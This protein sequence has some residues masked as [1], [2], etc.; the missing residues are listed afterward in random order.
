MLK[1]ESHGQV[2]T[3]PEVVRQMLALRQN[4]GRCLEPSCGDGAFAR[5]LPGCVAVELDATVAPEGALIQDFLTYGLENQFETII[6]NPPYVRYQRI[7]E[8]TRGH[9][10]SSLFDKRSNLYL[11]F[12]EK[13]VRHLVP[14]GELIFIV[15][16]EFIKLTAAAGLNEW[17]FSEGTITHFIEL[18]DA[19]V[20]KNASPNAAIFRFVRGCMDRRMAD[21]RTFDCINGQLLFR[22]ENCTDLTTLGQFFS[23]KV[24]AVSGADQLF[25]HP[26]GNAA[27]VCSKTA[28]TGMTRQMFYNLMSPVLLPHKERL[29]KRGI[30]HFNEANWWMWGR[31]FPENSLP[32]IY[33]NQKTR[34]PSP[35]FTHRSCA[36][37]GSILALFPTC[38]E[39]ELPAVC[40]V[41]NGIDW[42]ALGFQCGGRLLFSQ[43]S[44]ATC[45]LPPSAV[46][47]FEQLQRAAG[48]R[49][50]A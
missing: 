41:L 18:G 13:C 20:F 24:G 16:R 4:A 30:R 8:T 11:F 6:G 12:I 2:F 9:L 38:P 19:Q 50:P 21:G 15:P 47:A 14:G 39:V 7:L 46:A 23:V 17:L 44:L 49:R 27:F 25:A 42:Q 10:D 45:P 35:F 26:D 22:A 3:P 33:V 48:D 28:G 32:R 5:Q 29:L 1:V 34:R 37:D 31:A 43:R 40:A 36:F